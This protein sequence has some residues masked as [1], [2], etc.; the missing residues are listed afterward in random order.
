MK[1]PVRLL[2]PVI[3][4]I[5]IG[6]FFAKTIWK[7]DP[8]GY[9]YFYS[10]LRSWNRTIDSAPVPDAKPRAELPDIALLVLDTVR[11][12]SLFNIKTGEARHPQIREIASGARVFNNALS[13]S[14]W[15]VPSHASMMTGLYPNRHKADM[16]NWYFGE[17]APFLPELLFRN[18]YFTAGLTENPVVRS[19][20]GFSRGFTLFDDTYKR[21][22]YDEWKTFRS[23]PKIKTSLTPALVE[24]LA[25][26]EVIAGHPLFLFVNLI[27]PHWPYMPA[28]SMYEQ[29]P[30]AM[31]YKEAIEFQQEYTIVTWYL[32]QVSS[33]EDA[34]KLLR[35]L[36]ELEI[37]E[38]VKKV[39]KIVHALQSR[40][41]RKTVIFIV[42]D[43]GELFG[44]K[45][46]FAH[47]F[48]L[49]HSL[50]HVPMMVIGDGIEPGIVEEPVSLVDV[51]RT[52][53]ELAKIKP[54]E[55]EGENLLGSLPKERALF[56]SSA[57]PLYSMKFFDPKDRT[58]DLVA[59]LLTPIRAVVK[60]GWKMVVD[61]LGNRELYNLN[62]DPAESK[63]LINSNESISKTLSKL[64]DNYLA[65]TTNQYK[66]TRKITLDKK[67]ESNLRALG[68]V[69]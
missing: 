14:C 50:T 59:P 61:D 24:T 27:D 52:V 16:E 38:T 35:Y 6:L 31:S 23:S 40:A 32:Q 12:D 11:Y 2:I 62:E 21:L 17:K 19:E 65:R 63:N 47:M 64:L 42:A 7:K 51:F 30:G 25:N 37:R 29:K 33:S 45:G 53:C 67:T 26:H 3:A 20:T 44:Q 58:S 57:Y 15:T 8:G 34:M 66:A 55:N 36:Y 49:L 41:N 68:Y 13:T 48:N 39:Q 5:I 4:L 9:R 10:Q 22:F 54:P 1:S 18:G 46:H 69:Q 28:Q 60:N 56:F 43:H